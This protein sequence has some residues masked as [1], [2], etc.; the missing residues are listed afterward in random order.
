MLVSP[1]CILLVCQL[2]KK[3]NISVKK[4]DKNISLESTAPIL[5]YSYF[6]FYFSKS[7]LL[8]LTKDENI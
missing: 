1:E 7:S 6:Y 4:L 5:E 3:N 2:D 8:T